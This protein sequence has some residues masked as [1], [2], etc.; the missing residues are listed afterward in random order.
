MSEAPPTNCVANPSAST[1]VSNVMVVDSNGDQSPFT[2]IPDPSKPV[3]PG[4]V[5]R[6]TGCSL[7]DWSRALAKKGDPKPLGQ[8]PRLTPEE[9]SKHNTMD[10]MWMV[11][12]GVVY[13]CTQWQMFHP[14]GSA[15]LRDF[16]GKDVT[17]LNEYYHKWINLDALIGPCA[18]GVLVVPAE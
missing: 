17:L 15:I 11:I 1:D 13:D 6:A 16:A 18:V 10:D 8:L 9:V 12:N 4:K 5:P 3:R 2:V 14:G 7:G